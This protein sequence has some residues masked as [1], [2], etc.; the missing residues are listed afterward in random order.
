MFVKIY[1]TLKEI[2]QFTAIY[3][4][5]SWLSIIC[6][7]SFYIFCQIQNLLLFCFLSSAR[8]YHFHI[9]FLNNFVFQCLII[10]LGSQWHSLARIC[11]QYWNIKYRNNAQMLLIRLNPPH[12]HHNYQNNELCWVLC[13]VD[14]WTIQIRPRPPCC[15]L[16]FIL[17]YVNNYVNGQ[18][19]AAKQ[20][21]LEHQSLIMIIIFFSHLS[22]SLE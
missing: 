13:E 5:N 14:Q 21:S 19:L 11:Q 17:H 15:Q 9:F 6:M 8:N 4:S 1:C 18:F 7:Y 22:T 20:A 2:I 12:H 3:A 10:G 16:S